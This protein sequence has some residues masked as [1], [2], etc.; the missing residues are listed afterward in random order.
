VTPKPGFGRPIA[1][2]F[3]VYA[4]IMVPFVPLEA[5]NATR[6]LAD[7]PRFKRNAYLLARLSSTLGSRIIAVLLLGRRVSDV[8]VVRI[9]NNQT[10]DRGRDGGD[11][12]DSHPVDD[13][14]F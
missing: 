4:K 3:E 13:A 9:P 1:A 8:V 2:I 11:R 7:A 6:P 14:T 12:G 10:P 5:D